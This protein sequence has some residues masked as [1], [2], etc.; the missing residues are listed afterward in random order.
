[1]EVLR[2][3]H[4]PLCGKEISKRGPYWNR[5]PSCNDCGIFW[6]HACE[7][8]RGWDKGA[9][10]NMPDVCDECWMP[11]AKPPE[12]DCSKCD[13]TGYVN[14]PLGQQVCECVTFLGPPPP[15]FQ[16]PLDREVTTTWD[17]VP[18]LKADDGE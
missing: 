6:C 8:W 18:E 9:H 5:E 2:P 7:R 14:G 12:P 1:M 11:G 4:C 16:F 3:T 13:D 17:D 15:P 10:D